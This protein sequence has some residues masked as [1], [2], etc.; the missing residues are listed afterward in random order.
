MRLA[1]GAFIADFGLVFDLS[2]T[3]F[4]FSLCFLNSNLSCW[5]SKLLKSNLKFLNSKC[6]S[7]GKTNA[8]SVDNGSNLTKVMDDKELLCSNVL[9]LLFCALF[10]FVLYFPCEFVYIYNFSCL[11]TNL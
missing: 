10:C 7:E 2:N 11:F 3:K 1:R 6:P 5:L 4:S 8:G 9:L